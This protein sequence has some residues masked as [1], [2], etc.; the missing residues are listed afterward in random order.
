MEQFGAQSNEPREGELYAVVTVH[1]KR[2]ELRYGYYDDRDRG[3]PPD[4]IYPD[5]IKHPVYTD[6]GEPLITMMQDA[7]ERYSGEA[8]RTI[9][10][11]CAEC[12]HFRQGE[13]WFGICTCPKNKK[14]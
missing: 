11:T 12:K 14:L 1:G 8:K 6:S 2:F 7:C 9:D 3:E 13:E 5:L 10:T 4:V